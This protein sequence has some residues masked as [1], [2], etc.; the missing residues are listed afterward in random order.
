[1]INTLFSIFSYNVLTT[2]LTHV[3]LVKNVDVKY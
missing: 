1:M 3:Q 2:R